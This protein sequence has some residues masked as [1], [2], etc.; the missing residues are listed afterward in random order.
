MGSINGEE[1]AEWDS[2]DNS[3]AERIYVAVRARPLNEREIA[4]N[5]L[6]D[7]ECINNTTIIFKNSLQ[8]RSMLPSAYTFGDALSHTPLTFH[9]HQFII[10]YMT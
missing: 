8:E 6:S 7:W 1:A 9:Y 3:N 2:H 4:K 5:D 10:I